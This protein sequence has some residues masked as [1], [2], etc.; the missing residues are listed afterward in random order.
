M[1][2]FRS[3]LILLPIAVAA[4]V[5]GCLTGAR[6]TSQPASSQRFAWEGNQLGVSQVVPKPWTPLK[7]NGTAVEWWGGK[8]DFGQTLLPTQI[9]SQ[10]ADLLSRPVSLVLVADGK[11]VELPAT[12]GPQITARSD[13]AI[14]ATTKVDV[15]NV[16]ITCA[17]TV[18]FDGMLRVDMTASAQKACNLGPL[19]LQIPMKK[20]IASHYRHFYTYDFET[21]GVSRE[22]LAQSFGAT[23][24][25]WQ[26]SFCPYIWMGQPERGLEWFCQSDEEWQPHG[27]QDAIALKPSA[28]EVVLEARMIARPVRLNAGASWTVTF[29]LSPTPSKPR[30]PNWRNWRYAVREG[31]GDEG[32][33]VDDT[34]KYTVFGIFWS[35]GPDGLKSDIPTQPWPARPDAYRRA[36]EALRQ[37]RILYLPYGSLGGV[38]TVIPEWAVYGDQWSG[39]RSV[40]GWKY[41]GQPAKGSSTCLDQ[42]T[43]RDF[44]VWTYTEALRRLDID[45]IYFDYGAPGLNCINPL[46]PHGRLAGQG[47]YYTSLFSL[48]ELYKRLYIATHEVKPSCVVLAHGT[49]PT[50]AGSFVDMELDGESSQRYFNTTDLKYQQA[51][52]R[53]A[54]QKWYVPDYVAAWSVPWA[55]AQEGRNVGWFSVF[56]TEV[57]RRNKAYWESHLDEARKYM[58]GALAMAA[59]CDVHAITSGSVDAES[60]TLY[61]A[62]KGRFGPLGDDVAYHPFWEK[63]VEGD[64]APKTAIYPTLY[65]RPDRAL[66]ILSNLGPN[67]A[68]AMVDPHLE[69]L[70]VKLRD[71]RATEGMSNQAVPIDA[72]GKVTVTIAGKDLAVITLE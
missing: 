60:Y 16:T 42:A 46:H 47:I 13:G 44:V 57:T 27:R 15:G 64:V 4:V 3:P 23:D 69:K 58:R 17:N 72:N 45:G 71:N 7:L 40:S 56:L 48:R 49:M 63:V 66:L 5:A 67:T 31:A 21:N 8:I 33:P 52:Q 37:Q 61:E 68:Q 55:L 14:S 19:T 53:L 70:G 18:E 36:R 62:A 65:T 50:L 29:G 51:E 22:D 12:T 30:L 59:L 38:P 2:A 26:I 24:R 34:S 54:G 20:E 10:L 41:R 39:G 1:R 9:T 32:P 28:K 35:G 11:A 25:G 43:Y 6:G